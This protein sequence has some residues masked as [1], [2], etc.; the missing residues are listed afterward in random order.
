MKP[1][2]HPQTGN[3]AT[4][5]GAGF[6]S[7]RAR[8]GFTLLEIC[9][10]LVILG[11]LMGVIAPGMQSALAEAGVRSDARQLS[12]MVKTAMLQS[13]EEHKVYVLD[14]SEKNLSLGPLAP[15]TSQDGKPADPDQ[16][17]EPAQ[18]STQTWPLDAKNKLLLPDPD[19]RGHWQPIQSAQ[20]VFRPG[21]L[22]PASSVCFTRGEARLE[23]TFNALT[24]NVE[25]ERSVF[26]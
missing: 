25:E 8:R 9:I 11:V 23:V 3:A 19:G 14:L 22:C 24:G 20:W 12:L 2:A 15:F 4:R 21:E 5:G 7:W 17:L 10:V 26:P 6:F 16:P 13:V 1:V 18:D